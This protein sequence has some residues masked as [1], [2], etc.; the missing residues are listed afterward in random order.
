MTLVV[1][2]GTGIFEANSYTGPGFVRAYLAARNRE[3]DWIAVDRRVQNAALIAATE[4][5]DKRFGPRLLGQKEFTTLNVPAS[6]ILTF[7]ENAQE[8][9]AVTIGTETYT[10]K[11]TPSA[12]YEVEIG[13]NAQETSERLAG[14]ILGTAGPTPT[15]AHP[16]VSS[17]ALS[18]S[19]AVIVRALVPG[20]L[21]DA[22]GTSS[23]NPEISWDKPALSGGAEI[24]PQFLEF[25][26]RNLFT[27]EGRRVTGIPEALKQAVAEYASRA[28]TIIL[29]PDPEVDPSGQ[30]LAR[31]FDKIG[32]IETERRFV[33]SSGKDLFQRFPAADRL[34]NQFLMNTGQVFR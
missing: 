13:A 10:F 18:A 17:V 9:D 30:T 21:S 24:V 12:A 32:P 23:S 26:R 25:P 27:R 19:D 6:N 4:Y 8:D 15:P 2:D 5:I 22:I 29:M 33:F 7:Y 31:V 34:M 3:A 14:A 28:I 20:V 1:E 11:E 16:T